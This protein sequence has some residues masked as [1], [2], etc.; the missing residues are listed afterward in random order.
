MPKNISRNLQERKNKKNGGRGVKSKKPTML[1]NFETMLL[2]ESYMANKDVM[3]T[4]EIFDKEAPKETKR[5]LFY[6]VLGVY[7]S[8][9]KVSFGLTYYN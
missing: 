6:Y 7:K 9:P 5:Y 8:Q 2:D 1:H 4:D 3:L